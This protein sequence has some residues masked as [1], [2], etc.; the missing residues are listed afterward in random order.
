VLD[1][2][3]EAFSESIAVAAA[4]IA[5]TPMSA[6]SL[7]DADRQWFK[8]ACGLDL[9]ETARS[10]SFCAHAILQQGPLVVTDATADERFSA[11]PMVA[12]A[13]H[14][15][16][17]AGFQLVARGHAVGALCVFDDRRRQLTDDQ[18]QQLGR[19]AEATSAWLTGYEHGGR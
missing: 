13:P 6:I 3:P 11:N 12:G 1:T 14:V 15:R 16:F 7:V 4:A 9:S 5:N 10:V 8:G 17:Y 2:A 19:L 18:L